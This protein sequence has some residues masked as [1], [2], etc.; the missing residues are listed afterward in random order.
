MSNNGVYAIFRK[1]T[2]LILYSLKN[3]IVLFRV[4]IIDL[5]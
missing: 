4:S 2:E 5:L 1:N 3:N